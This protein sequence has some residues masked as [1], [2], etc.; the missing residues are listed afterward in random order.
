MKEPTIRIRLDAGPA[1]RALA[2][3]G[4]SI[5]LFDAIRRGFPELATATAFI[6]G[7]LLI[8]KG[9]ADL[10]RPAVWSISIGLLLMSLCG[11]SLVRTIVVRG[12]YL[13][14]VKHKKG[15]S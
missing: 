12:L 9:I 5:R 15:D 2:A 4:R 1:L 11:W 8:T 6:A 7:W 3:I 13:L 14:N 10:T